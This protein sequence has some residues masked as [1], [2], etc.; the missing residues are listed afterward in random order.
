MG[1]PGSR[2]LMV[3]A[4]M[5]HKLS[6][7]VLPLSLQQSPVLLPDILFL[8]SVHAILYPPGYRTARRAPPPSSTAHGRRWE[9]P[10]HKAAPAHP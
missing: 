1:G 5:G 6:S 7:A 4:K 9:Q 2:G 10:R 3:Q 8:I